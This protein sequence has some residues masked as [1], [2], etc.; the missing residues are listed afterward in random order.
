MFK[1]AKILSIILLLIASVLYL[2][3]CNQSEE[4]A[5]KVPDNSGSSETAETTTDDEA[6][7]QSEEPEKPEK[8]SDKNGLTMED[9]AYYD[10]KEGRPAYIVIEGV[11]YD[12]TNVTHWAEGTHFG[13]EAGTDMT[14]A[15]DVEA[16]HEADLLKEAEVVGKIKN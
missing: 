6:L 11:I 7:E 13:F 2:S 9:I 16:P 1:K 8:D 3:A 15:L 14:D 4:A 10:G 12:V 5:D